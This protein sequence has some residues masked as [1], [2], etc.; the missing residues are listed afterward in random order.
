MDQLTAITERLENEP[1]IAV[2]INSAANYAVLCRNKTGAQMQAE[3]GSV[4]DWFNK[5]LSTTPNIIVQLK[6][7]NGSSHINLGESIKLN[8]APV[9]QGLNAP[10]YAPT[11]QDFQQPVQM[12]PGLMAGLNQLDMV[13]RHQ[14]YPKVIAENTELKAE[15]KILKTEVDKLKY[16]ALENRFSENKANGNKEMLSGFLAMAPEIFAMLGRGAAPVA[17]APGLGQPTHQDDN[18]SDSKYNLIQV[19]RENQ[20][21]VSDYLFAIYNGMNT[22]QE[23]G[24]ELMELLKKYNLT[25]TA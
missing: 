4:V 23:F 9:D 16:E 18:L 12:F 22:N 14:D 10:V 11:H 6:R 1:T 24:Q 17:A 15:N 2:S 19:I 13:Y 20:D 25:T 5:L 3:A 21:F 7:K 8:A